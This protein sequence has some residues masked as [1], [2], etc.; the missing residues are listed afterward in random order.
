MMRIPDE[1]AIPQLLEETFLCEN[2]EDVAAGLKKGR[3][4]GKELTECLT[5][6]HTTAFKRISGRSLPL[7]EVA[8]KPAVNCKHSPFVEIDALSVIK[9]LPNV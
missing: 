4:N 8:E 2:P 9:L 6:L 7:F 1:N 3:L 5:T